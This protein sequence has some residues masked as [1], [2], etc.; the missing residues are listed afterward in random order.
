[1]LFFKIITVNALSPNF[2]SILKSWLYFETLSVLD[3]EP[4]LICPEQQATDKSEIV[5]S[6]VSPDL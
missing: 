4:V 1:M 6:S 2:S 3:N 5:T